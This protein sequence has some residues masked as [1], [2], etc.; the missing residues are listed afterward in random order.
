MVSKENENKI[1][2]TEKI[3]RFMELVDNYNEEIALNFLT[4]AEWD[5][6]VNSVIKIDRQQQFYLSR[7]LQIMRIPLK[8]TLIKKMKFFYP[9]QIRRYQIQQGI[10]LSIER[11]LVFSEDFL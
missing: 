2:C 6:N 4:K 5:E 9:I 7:I 11:G 1:D 10:Q 3:R 8:N